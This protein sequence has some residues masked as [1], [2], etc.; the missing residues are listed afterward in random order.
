MEKLLLASERKHEFTIEGK[1]QGT[2]VK[3]QFKCKYPSVLDEIQIEV[4]SSNLI[5]E[6]NPSTLSNATYDVSYMIAYNNVLLEE[7]PQWYDLDILDNYQI[8]IEVYN[9]IKN[10][11]DNFRKGNEQSTDSASSNES[12]D[13]GT[14]ESK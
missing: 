6:A 7:K 2:D 10:F 1:V 13:K 5:R 8:I 11:V 12:R 3:G 14:V 9:E 4:Q